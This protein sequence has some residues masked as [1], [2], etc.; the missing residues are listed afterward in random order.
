MRIV[1]DRRVRKRQDRLGGTVV[2]LKFVHLCIGIYPFESEDIFDLRAPP[3]VDGLIVVADD[4]EV[5]VHGRKAFDD[6]ELYG[7]GILKFVYVDVAEPARKVGERLGVLLQKGERLGQKIVEIERVV[8]LQMRGVLFIHSD[9]RLRIALASAALRIFGG[10]KPHHFGVGNMP[11]DRLQQLTV[12]ILIAAF[13][14]RLFDNG[15][16]LLLGVDGKVRRK[17]LRSANI[18]KILTHME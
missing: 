15:G 18:L 13:L 4:E 1:R 6:L 16:A 8:C 10:R 7:V 2:L 17:P 11:F 12:P 9:S 5:P 3:A 14:E